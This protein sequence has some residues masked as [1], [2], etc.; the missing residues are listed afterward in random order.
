MYDLHDDGNPNCLLE[1]SA[2][3]EDLLHE[4]QPALH[5]S[6]PIFAWPLSPTKLLLAS[7]DG[8]KERVIQRMSSFAKNGQF[9]A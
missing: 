5:P 2:E 9:S 4:S 8:D 6:A 7:I 1:F 3:R